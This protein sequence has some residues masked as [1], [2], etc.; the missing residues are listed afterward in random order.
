MIMILL[1]ESGDLTDIDYDENDNYVRNT[2]ITNTITRR[3]K[4]IKDHLEKQTMMFVH[5]YQ[6]MVWIHKPTTGGGI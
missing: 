3:R 6:P 2:I 5:E 4:L 1:P